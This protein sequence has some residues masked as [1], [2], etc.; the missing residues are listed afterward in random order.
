M[1]EA[2]KVSEEKRAALAKKLDDDLDAFMD[3]MA[4]RKSSDPA[5]KK[6]FNFDEW[7]KE[8]DQHPAFMTDLKPNADGEHSEFVQALQAIKYD[9]GETEEERRE[10]A[11]GHK[12]E[13]NKHF[14]LKKY[15]WAIEAYTN[16]VKVFC[17]DK[18]LNSVLYANRAAANKNIGNL[19]S[20][21]KDCMLA[22]RFD[23]QNGKAIVRCAECFLELGYGRETIAWVSKNIGILDKS[24]EGVDDELRKGQVKKLQEVSCSALK[25]QEVQEREERKEKMAKKR[26][27]EKKLAF[28][29]A[30]K[31][32]NL[33]FQPPMNLEVPELFDWSYITVQISQINEETMVKMDKRG[34]LHWPIL[35]QYP[36]HGQ[37]NMLTDCSELSALGAIVRD[38]LETPE[39][40]GRHIHYKLGNIKFFVPLDVFDEA[41]LQEVS[42]KEILK[43]ILQT[44][45]FKIVW[46]M[47]VIQIYRT[48]YAQKS[49][50]ALGGGRFKVL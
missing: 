2:K 28:M 43:T 49:L 33:K 3:E 38:C 1:A 24:I 39:E 21:I 15:R 29:K 10:T 13:G 47:P 4:R 16:G 31:E 36:E 18:K 44:K 37:T 8:I 9:T 14:K 48:E 7:C 46:G 40:W 34:V 32:R 42:P 17:N 12:I 11:E 26:E 45:D 30:F 6:P 27:D 50:K 35:L 5:A 20:A 25:A 19:R 41:I 22:V 23:P